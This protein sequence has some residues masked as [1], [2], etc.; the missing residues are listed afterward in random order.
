MLAELK[1]IFNIV[2]EFCIDNYIELLLCVNTVALIW[3][4]ICLIR[5]MR[6]M[7]KKKKA[8]VSA[9][10][11]EDLLLSLNIKRADV[12]IGSIN[13]DFERKLMAESAE[14]T[15]DGTDEL[16]KA[17]ANGVEADADAERKETQDKDKADNPTDAGAAVVIEKLIPT[18]AE[19]VKTA[20]F[21]TSRNG[22]VY[23]EEEILQQIKD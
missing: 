20:G 22:K 13:E 8:A 7:K 4:A 11:A 10:S 5:I 18:A 6:G 17:C 3:A 15:K 21:C 19:K 12:N 1:E 2:K 16:A 9:D 23:S 14:S